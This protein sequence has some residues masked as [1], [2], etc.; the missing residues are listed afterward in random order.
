M[1]KIFNP[2]SRLFRSPTERLQSEISK[3]IFSTKTSVIA[4][5]ADKTILC[6]NFKG[7]ALETFPSLEKIRQ[8]IKDGADVNNIEQ[9]GTPLARCADH[10]KTMVTW[11]NSPSSTLILANGHQVTKQEWSSYADRFLDAAKIL[12]EAGADP[13]VAPAAIPEATATSALTYRSRLSDPDLI[14]D[15]ADLLSSAEAALVKKESQ[16]HGTG[17]NLK[18]KNNEF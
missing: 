7:D 9:A 16:K 18:G 8:L 12:V 3:S 15:F 13:R 6:S 2:I 14:K 11:A 10:Y 4:S 5:D 1:R 17:R